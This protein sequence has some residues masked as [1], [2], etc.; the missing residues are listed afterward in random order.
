MWSAQWKKPGVNCHVFFHV[1]FVQLA[2]QLIW[3]IFLYATEN[4]ISLLWHHFHGRES[5]LVSQPDCRMGSF[6]FQL[7]SSFS[8]Q[9]VFQGRLTDVNLL[10]GSLVLVPLQHCLWSLFL[11]ILLCQG[12]TREL[13]LNSPPLLWDYALSNWEPSCELCSKY[14]RGKIASVF[15]HS[16]LWGEREVVINGHFFGAAFGVSPH[17]LKK[18]VSSCSA[19]VFIDNVRVKILFFWIVFYCK[20]YSFISQHW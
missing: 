18:A 19:Y 2:F 16:Q 15:S 5:D 8:T 17:F 7:Y 13:C 10:L 20:F 9:H 11:S 14:W 3:V 4:W 6:K 1:L 12:S